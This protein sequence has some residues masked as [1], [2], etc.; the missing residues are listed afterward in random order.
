MII[1]VVLIGI[2]SLPLFS[3]QAL[4][5]PL[6]SEIIVSKVG[7]LF[8]GILF[9]AVASAILSTMDTAINT[10]ALGLTRDFYQQV[11]PSAK[12][13]PVLVSRLA[14]VLVGALAFLISTRFQSI[15]KTIGLSSEILAEGF[16]VP[17]LAM[18]Y[19]K[20]RLPSAGLLSLCFGG[21]FAVLS[22][23]GAM[24]VLPFNL[25][26]WP[27]SVPYGLLLSLFGFFVGLIIDLKKKPR[28]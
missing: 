5:R 15:L 17:G 12:K 24:N 25:P 22:F 6:I 23:L 3:V 11:F 4:S 8:G 9:I 19:L 27:Y 26:T 28:L 21:G 14:T 10:G 20:R 1:F 13:R 18:I 7:V 16:F 2:F